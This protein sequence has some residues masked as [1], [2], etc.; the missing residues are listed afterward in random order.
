MNTS[1]LRN[2]WIFETR[3]REL[4]V[5]VL[6]AL[7][8]AVLTRFWDE[9][10]GAFGALAFVSLAWID[11]GH[12]YSTLLRTHVHRRLC[13]PAVSPWLLVGTLGIL[14][15]WILLGIPGLWSFVTYATVFHHFRQFHGFQR[16]AQMKT[17]RKDPTSDL[18]LLGLCVIPLL[19]YHY[20]T[21]G[22]TLGDVIY[23]EKDLFLNPG[24]PWLNPEFMRA[25]LSALYIGI[26]TWTLGREVALYSRGVREPARVLALIWPAILYGYS[27]LLTQN[28]LQMLVPLVLAHGVPYFGVLAE[29]IYKVRTWN[30]SSAK[31]ALLAAA[32]FG[33]LLG[34]FEHWIE[35]VW[36]ETDSTYLLPG[37]P[38]LKVAI[39]L[40]LTPL[41]YHY[42]ADAWLWR[43]SHPDFRGTVTPNSSI[44]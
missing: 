40:Y 24:A 10:S 27:F 25:F 42:V 31:T 37:H 5:F 7:L 12:V 44:T 36:I 22:R 17:G 8:G 20:P 11:A 32:A 9:H 3:G 29:R 6:P 19:L 35:E 28:K 39:A 2:P 38:V 30:W 34:T 13:P 33:F 14:L 43:R 4:S 21:P 26:I 15:S 41:L 23:T 16:W 1:T 18:L